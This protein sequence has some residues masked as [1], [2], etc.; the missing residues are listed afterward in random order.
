VIFNRQIRV[1][2][3]LAPAT[4]VRLNV[5]VVLVDVQLHGGGR[6]GRERTA[7]ALHH[8]TVTADFEVF[9]LKRRLGDGTLYRCR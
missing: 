5:L 1:K 6:L 2:A 9:R 4:R 3:F 7:H 8:G